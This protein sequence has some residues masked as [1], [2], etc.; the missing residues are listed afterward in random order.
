MT[1]SKLPRIAYQILNAA[2]GWLAQNQQVLRHAKELSKPKTKCKS[3]YLIVV[4]RPSANVKLPVAMGSNVAQDL[5]AWNR[6]PKRT[7]ATVCPWSTTWPILKRFLVFYN[8]NLIKSKRVT[9]VSKPSLTVLVQKMTRN[10]VRT[11]HA[12]LK[13]QAVVDPSASQIQFRLLRTPA[14]TSLPLVITKVHTGMIAAQILLVKDNH[15]TLI[16]LPV[17]PMVLREQHTKNSSSI[18]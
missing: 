13:H 7:L 1:A 14:S 9:R 10:A 4:Y 8:L 5:A 3:C 11:R 6:D 2:T 18:L 16:T 15:N 17:Y 12:R